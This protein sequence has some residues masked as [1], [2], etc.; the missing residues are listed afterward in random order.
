MPMGE[1]GK[2][3]GRLGEEEEVEIGGYTGASLAATSSLIASASLALT[4][5]VALVSVSSLSAV[6]NPSWILPNA[7][8]DMY[9]SQGEYWGKS[10]A[11]LA[12][13]RASVGYASDLSGNWTSFSSNVARI[14]NQ[15][16][17]VEEART[18]LF[19]NSQ[20][21]VT[22]TVTV[23]S[24]SVY[25]VSV[26]GT[27]SVVLSDATTQTVTS[28]AAYTFTAGSTSLVCTVSGAGGTFQNVQVE[29]GSFATSPIVTTG[30]SA[31]RAAD[32]VTVTS[33]PTLGS[34]FSLFVQGI[35]NAPTAYGTTQD[36]M[37]MDDGSFS[38]YIEFKRSSSSGVCTLVGS[39]GT[40]FFFGSTAL[41]PNVSFKVAYSAAAGAQASYANGSANGTASAATL[42]ANLSTT[43]I[44]GS[45]GSG[46]FFNGII[47]RVAEWPTIP[48]NSAQQAAIT[49]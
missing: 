44:I 42:P 1:L 11:D 16:L 24:S 8:I 31:T 7:G 5:K 6:G 32:V 12:C 41:S 19:L 48:L 34:A 33:P 29:L 26:Y 18:N 40:G 20:A 13:T 4:T 43:F 47:Q 9:F 23:V 14:T 17:L 21:P 39:G 25:T 22:Q 28:A 49:Q 27:A 35:P 46:S 45:N 3:F 10:D 15:G 37:L 30:A 36:I 38:N 2:E